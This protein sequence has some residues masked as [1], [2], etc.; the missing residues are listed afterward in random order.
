[1]KKSI[2][3]IALSLFVLAFS[4]RFYKYENN[5]GFDWDQNR[6]YGEVRQ[7][8]R[9][10]Y[11]ILGPVAKGSGGFYLG[12][13][14]YYLLFP[15]YKIMQGSLYA[16]P[17]T[18][19]VIDSLFVGCLFYL[20]H[21]IIGKKKA[22]LISLI[23]A[24]SW[25]LIQGSRVSWNVALVPIWSLVTLY[26]LYMVI[27]NRSLKHF[28][29]LGFLFGL[30]F[31]IHVAVIPVIPIFGILYFKHFKF[32]LKAWITMLVFAITPLIP[33][34][35]FDLK[36]GLMNAHLLR[37]QLSSVSAARKSTSML[38]NMSLIKLGKVVSGIFLAKFA[39]NFYLG[40]FTIML[41][42]KSTCFSKNLIY[43]LAGLMILI[44]TALI[45]ALG[46][47]GFPEYYFAG[48]YLAI[49][50]IYISLL[51]YIPKPISIIIILLVIYANMSNFS[52]I[53]SGFSLKYK[54]DLIESL[55]EF[56]PPIDISYQ[57]DPGRDG[58]FRYIVDLQGI[59]TDPVSRTRVLLTDKLKTPLYI[60]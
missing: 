43:K 31:H 56:D 37:D 22:F 5:A 34:I 46:D 21:K 39:D 14:Y 13:L 45:V 19:I 49:L 50:I 52:T 16:L 25:T 57:F 35:A 51:A 53:P 42:I 26:S 12:S 29:L 33:L 38:L 8:A 28:Y 17:L 1:M 47:Y 3:I 20:L 54:Y 11:V 24:I 44:A 32:A 2:W 55:K 9:G 18:S 10:H 7:I 23:W 4:L 27:K 48:V 41:A 60:G 40:L 30:T 58:G 6:D 36:H 59:K 15:A